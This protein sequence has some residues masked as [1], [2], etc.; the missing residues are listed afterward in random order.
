[1]RVV[2]MVVV[3]ERKFKMTKELVVGVAR[4]GVVADVECVYPH[5]GGNVVDMASPTRFLSFFAQAD[6]TLSNVVCVHGERETS[7]GGAREWLYIHAKD[8]WIGFIADGAFAS[9]LVQLELMSRVAAL[10]MK[11]KVELD[12]ISWAHFQALAVEM[13]QKGVAL[14]YQNWCDE[15]GTQDDLAR[16]LSDVAN[17]LRLKRPV[18]WQRGIVQ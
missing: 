15:V 3:K 11:P 10:I 5:D 2:P 14:L 18:L 6:G 9:E 8:N 1:M 4:L 13:T 12:S 7:L 16:A 17:V